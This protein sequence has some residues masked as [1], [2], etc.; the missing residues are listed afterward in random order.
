MVVQSDSHCCFS[1]SSCAVSNLYYVFNLFTLLLLKLAA[2]VGL[3]TV[4]RW[5]FFLLNFFFRLRKPGLTYLVRNYLCILMNLQI[6]ASQLYT[7]L[8][9]F[10][11]SV[12]HQKTA[13]ITLERYYQHDPT[14]KVGSWLV[15]IV[16]HIAAKEPDMTKLNRHY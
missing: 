2:T 14:N 12:L 15:N 7:I 1:C 4:C 8:S 13:P 10:Q 16:L 11:L 9:I 3:V 5:Y 6:I